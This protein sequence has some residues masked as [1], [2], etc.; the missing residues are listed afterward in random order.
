M[1]KAW[2]IAYVAVILVLIAVLLS[3]G[4]QYRTQGCAVNELDA[5]YRRSIRNAGAWLADRQHEI[6]HA[7]YLYKGMPIQGFKPVAGNPVCQ[8]GCIVSVDRVAGIDVNAE[9]ELIAGYNETMDKLKTNKGPNQASQVMA[10]KLAEP[11]R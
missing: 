5:A 11:E 9:R 10:R 1:N 8:L 7:T 2:H 6:G 4:R 3:L